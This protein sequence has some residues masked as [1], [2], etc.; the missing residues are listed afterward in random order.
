M[1]TGLIESTAV[2]I[3]NDNKGDAASLVLETTLAQEMSIGDSLAVN[4]VCLT[5]EK[6]D[7]LQLQFHILSETLEK[8]NLAELNSGDRVNLERPLKVGDR[9][10]GHICSGHVDRT[11]A[12]LDIIDNGDEEDRVLTI[13]VNEDMKALL[14]P[15]GSIAIDGISLTIAKLEDEQLSVHLIPH[16]WKITNLSDKNIGD[17]VNIELDNMAKYILRYKS[18]MES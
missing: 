13:A 12:I 9:L 1:F 11:T 8:S 15:K 4:G 3:S 17:K 18:L 16:T 14:I 5:V 7:E 2:V 6:I 10:D